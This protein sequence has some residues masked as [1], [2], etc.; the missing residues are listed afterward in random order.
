MSEHGRRIVFVSEGAGCSPTRY[1]ALAYFPQLRAAGWRPSHVRVVGLWR[2]LALLQ[3]VRRADVV[4]IL[5]KLFSPPFCRLLKANGRRL[6]YDFDD[7]LYVQDDGRPDPDRTRYFAAMMRHV[8]AVWAGNPTL[9][10]E[11]APFAPALVLPT[12]LET[13][14]Y[15][16]P[17]TAAADAFDVVWIGSSATRKY[18]EAILPALAAAA[19]EIPT[20]RLNI[21]ADFDLPHAHAL[22]VP[23][24]ATPWTQQHEAAALRNA[25]VGIAPL[26][27][28]PWTRGKC[29]LKILQCMAAG[30]PVVASP[31]AV[32]REMVTDALTG[33]LAAT[34]DQW[35]HAL[36]RLHDDPL[37][38][39]RMG[40]AG[41]TRVTAGYSV[42]ATFEKMRAALATLT[43]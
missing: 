12:S 30:L 10:A 11:A 13:D 38:R 31:V 24:R 37:L 26:P 5:R 8:D 25:H 41:R 15:A 3:A 17:S 34:D 6:I 19:R 1:R 23:T 36:R 21:V 29:G 32:Q 35:L 43:G 22:G 20:L 33:F 16:G 4:V 39:T 28:D 14:K 40:T 42:E 7:A 9:A 18:L 2:R 27:D